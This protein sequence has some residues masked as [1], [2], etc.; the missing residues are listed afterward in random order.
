MSY[1]APYDRASDDAATRADRTSVFEPRFDDG[2]GGLVDVFHDLTPLKDMSA[3]MWRVVMRARMGSTR[4]TD[5]SGVWR[6]REWVM[7]ELPESEMICAGEGNAPLVEGERLT[8]ALG[9]GKLWIK[10]CGHS[11]TGSFKDLGMTVLVSMAAAMRKRGADIRA[12][13]C[14]STGDTSAALAG[15]GARAQLPVVVLLPAGKI[16]AAQLTQPL[17]NGAHVFALDGDFDACMKVVQ[18]LTTAPGMFLANSKNPLRLEGQK[19]VAFEIAQDLGWEVPDFVVVPSGNLGNV[20]ALYK[21]FSLLLALGLIE[22]LPRLVAAQVDAANPL[23]RA[24]E[25]GGESLDALTA[26]PTQASAIRIG[27]PVSWPRA[28]IALRETNGLVTSVSEDAV[29]NV[30]A[31]A[32]RAGFFVCPHT[33][34]ALA[35]VEVLRQANTIDE[36]ARVV[37]VSTAHGLKFAEQ[38]ARFHAGEDTV[39]GVALGA[40]L[41]A[42]RNPIRTC[43]P[44]ARLSCASLST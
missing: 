11:L 30:S 23:F 43:A 42:D 32:D 39:D 2:N 9:V 28:Q 1:I 13:L 19:T 22:K 14:A 12:L 25:S 24:W 6:Y 35:G 26:A 17:A 33:A 44:T 3:E 38:K 31:Q 21:G 41:D 36:T 37:V 15:Y 20:S 8:E 16:T 29:A 34:A 5:R 10:Q 4:P 7:P 18:D 40:S 27:A